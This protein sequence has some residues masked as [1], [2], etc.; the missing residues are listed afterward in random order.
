MDRGANNPRRFRSPRRRGGIYI[1]VLGSSMILTIVGLTGLAAV[2]IQRVATE[3]AAGVVEARACADAGVELAMTYLAADPDW[4]TN[5]PN[6]VWVQDLA[7]GSG[8]VTVE[9]I[10]PDDGSLADSDT[11]RLLLR[12][13]G[14]LG[15]ARHIIEVTLLADPE[16][17]DALRT[18][19]HTGGQLS[20]QSG[21]KLLAGGGVVST[22][23]S[24]RNAG[25]IDG[26]VEAQ[27]A[28]SVGTVTGSVTLAAPAKAMPGSDVVARYAA[29]GTEI[30]PGGSIDRR[31]LTAGRNP[32]GS[33]NAAGVY[34]IRTSGDLRIRDT[35]IHGTLVV[36]CPG[37]TVTVENAALL[38]P[39]REDYPALIVDGN[40]ELVMDDA[41]LSESSAGTNFNPSDA[42][43]EGATDGDQADTYPSEVRGLVHV[44]GTLVL[45]DTATVRGTILV[46]SAAISNAVDC[47]DTPTLAYEPELYESPPMG[48]ASSVPMRV[49]PGSW[50]RGVL[51]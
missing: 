30:S 13:T 34:V 14:V 6:G 45:S 27:S 3:A 1:A 46:E 26:S 19:L 17:L 18:A 43:Y 7:I 44:L 20:V 51:P 42:A 50:R 2:R 25:M 48:Y 23:G 33:P 10:D 38:H 36:I 8:M 47:Q 11:D 39:H 31:V 9:G 37:G 35:R 29:L 32:W 49:E 5:R 16:P 41:V 40:L 24:L 4:R 28:T 15:E 22:N 12:S 21:A